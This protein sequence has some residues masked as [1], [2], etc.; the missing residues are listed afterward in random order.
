MNDRNIRYRTV[1]LG[2]LMV[3][4]SDSDKA[5]RQLANWM[6]YVLY[7]SP[8]TRY[9]VSRCIE[10]KRKTGG[11]THSK[12]FH[13][14]HKSLLLLLGR[15]A[16]DRKSLN[17]LHAKLSHQTTL[18]TECITDLPAAQGYFSLCISLMWPSFSPLSIAW[19]DSGLWEGI[20]WKEKRGRKTGG[21]QY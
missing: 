13:P 21:W 12:A 19:N 15:T 9:V 18:A 16:L 17:P 8:E 20:K 6:D 10:I 1:G 5:G 14:I 11:N 3:R 7:P 4:W 2:Q